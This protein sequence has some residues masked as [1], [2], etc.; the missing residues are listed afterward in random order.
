[1]YDKLSEEETSLWPMPI[2]GSYQLLGG[3]PA[4]SLAPKL[5]HL[6]LSDILFM[7]LIMSLPREHRPWGIVT[8]MSGVFLLSR[9]ALYDLTERVQNRL[10]DPESEEVRSLPERERVGELVVS[11][12]RIVRTALS[13]TFPGNVSLRPLQNILSEAFD[14][15][16][17]VG[18]LSELLSEAG[19]RAGELLGEIDT[20]PLQNVI[21]A[22]DETFFLGQPLL[23]VIDPVSTVILECTVAPD[24]TAETWGIVLMMA[25]DQGATLGGLVE[26]MATMYPASQK[27]AELDVDVQKDVWH[28][29]RDGGKVRTSLENAAFKAIQQVADL[30]RKLLKKWDDDLFDNH[31]IQAVAQEEK[32]IEQYDAF[33]DAFTHLCDALEVV[34]IRSGEIRDKDTNEWLFKETL[35]LLESI[36]HPKVTS[37]FKTLRNHQ[38][39]LL[40]YLEWLATSLNPY[41]D[42]LAKTLRDPQG[43]TQ[44]IRLVARI[45]RLRQAVINGS[46]HLKTSLHDSEQFLKDAIEQ[47]PILKQMATQLYQILDAACRSSSMI[48]NING[49]LKRFLRARRSFNSTQTLQLYL[50]LFTLWHN[51]RV[52]QR[53]KRKGLSPYQHAGINTESQDWLTMLGY[54]PL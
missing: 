34:D 29:E 13:A 44:F 36:N 17:S 51:M 9:P 23:L 26:D 10:L 20:S 2:E 27:E 25:Q 30:E 43:R 40:Q 54:P 49:L 48:E 18:W 24:R 8:W 3:G 41:K 11:R 38:K 42:E 47:Y 4:T 7:T 19:T 39:Q 52:Y 37:W 14:E 15:E 5:T 50:N 21:A 1:M 31:Y 45:W 32:A 46:P 33:C 6:G 16:R 12:E 35:N 53:G 28:I 22:R